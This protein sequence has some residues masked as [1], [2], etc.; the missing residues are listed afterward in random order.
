MVGCAPSAKEIAVPLSDI[1]LSIL[2]PLFLAVF[3]LI[4]IYPAL[5]ATAEIIR[6][7]VHPPA[8]SKKPFAAPHRDVYADMFAEQPGSLPMND[9][10]IIVLRRL[11]QAGGRSLSR[12]QVNE[13][14]LLGSAVLNK[15]L[16]SLHRRGMIYVTLSRLLEQRFFLSEAGRRYAVE[17]GYI[18]KIQEHKGTLQQSRM[19]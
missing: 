9:F 2:V 3:V 15:T 17:Q 1:P 19:P 18:I 8:T 4:G 6:K 5:R 13:P 12:K 16:R 11:A 10:E 7:L 14:L